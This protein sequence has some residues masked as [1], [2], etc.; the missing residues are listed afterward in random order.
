MTITRLPRQPYHVVI[1]GGGGTGGALAHDLILRGFRVTLVER[2]E[3]TSGTTG[4]HHGL[5][6]S[7]ARYAVKDRESAVE[8]IEE[9]TIL[10]RVC[11]GSFE[12]NDGLFVAITDED[13]AYE[14]IFVESCLASGIPARRVTRAEALRLEPN[15]NPDLKLAVQVP[16]A[17]MDAMR[18]PLRFFAT[19]KAGGAVIRPWT[20]VTELLVADRLVSG[21]R[22]RDLTNGVEEEIHADLVVNA[23]GPWAEQLAVMAGCDVP[24]RPSPGVLLAVRGRW[25]NMVINRLHPSGD[26]DIVVPQRGLSVIGTSSWVVED[27]DD[28]GVPE[29]HVERMYAEGS[30]MIPAIRTAERRA[31]WSAARPLIGSRDAESGR[32]L[33]RT[34]KCLDHRER[35]AWRLRTIS[36][37]QGTTSRQWPRR[38]PKCLRQGRVEAPCQDAGGRDPPHPRTTRRRSGGMTETV[39]RCA[40]RAR[41]LP[42]QGDDDPAEQ[43]YD[44]FDV[45]VGPRST[46]LDAL[47]A[48]AVEDP[49]L[50]SGTPLPRLC[51]RAGWVGRPE[52]L[53]CVTQVPAGDEVSSSRSA[54]ARRLRPR[55]RHEAL[56]RT[57]SSRRPAAH[58]A[59]GEGSGRRDGRGNRRVRALR[60]LLE[61]GICLSACPS[62]AATRATRV[63]RP[64][65]AWRVVE[66][67]ADA[68]PARSS[69]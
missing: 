61:C 52:G 16:D 59:F 1:V 48:T 62:R 50:T 21:I 25:S 11:P 39:A 24:I 57:T 32:E 2:G 29:D 23:T 49:S 6:H 18:M 40:R 53:A 15:L 63:R 67:R 45:A 35:M 46:I 43:R 65:R 10:G 44:T 33:S 9:R 36:G 54:T 31:A 12:E 20:L 7:G 4:R 64:G 60:G 41:S 28:L 30:A 51:G 22:V 26:G 58:P 68:I 69:G 66:E 27:P 3:V 19:A 14:P 8:C 38:R 55:R 56:L 13:V 5:L 37:G 47:V 42:S 34:F 17:T